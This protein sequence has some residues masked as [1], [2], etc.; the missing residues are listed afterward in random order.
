MLE[1]NKIYCGDAYA[2]LKTIPDNTIHTGITSPPYYS[3]GEGL[4]DY[5]RDPV[6]KRTY[7]DTKVG[8]KDGWDGDLGMEPTPQMYIHHLADIC[9]EVNRVLRPD[10]T[11][12]LNLGDSRA[13]SGRGNSGKNAAIQNQEERQGFIGK[14]VIIPKGFKKKDVFGIPFRVGIE[15]QERGWYWR[16]T[17]PWLK[18][19]GMIGSY[20]DRPVSNIEWILILTKTPNN[21]YDSVAVMEKSSE[22]YLK[23]KRPKGVLRQRTNPNTKYNREEGQFKKQDHAGNSTYKNFNQRYKEAGSCDKRLLRSSDF[24]FKTWQGLWVDEEGDPLAMI[25]NPKAYRGKHFAGFPVM[26]PQTCIAASTSEKGVCPK[27]GAPWERQAEKVYSEDG[28]DYQIITNG[29]EPSCKCG[30]E[31][32]VPATVL[33]FFAGT[34][35]TGVACKNL[36]RGYIG[37]EINPM[38]CQLGETRIIEEGITEIGCYNEEKTKN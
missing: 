30:C 3:P 22:S 19:N 17:I 12:W 1:R 9:D 5:R 2:I 25:V 24:F 11:F 35:S 31:S 13:G 6:T 36:N 18:R 37:I 14:R 33:D 27:C 8:W 20:K 16:D 32:T 29:W 4:R 10:G 34:S 23:D 28:K 7:F 38:Y 21:Y 15:L 26:L